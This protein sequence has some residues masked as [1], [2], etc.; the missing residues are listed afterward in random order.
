MKK[1]FSLAKA[2]PDENNDSS[3]ADRSINTGLPTLEERALYLARAVLGK[4][5]FTGAELDQARQLIIEA[6]AEEILDQTKPG[7]TRTTVRQPAPQPA[8]SWEAIEQVLAEARA[9]LDDKPQARYSA[10]YSLY[11]GPSLGTAERLPLARE[12]RSISADVLASIRSSVERPHHHS[13]G[14]W[15]A[16]IAATGVLAVTAIVWLG[17]AFDWLNLGPTKA[18]RTAEVQT[19]AVRPAASTVI[20]S[21]GNPVATQQVG[22]SPDRRAQDTNSSATQDTDKPFLADQ[23]LQGRALIASGQ[24]SAGRTILESATEAGSADAALALAT[25]HDPLFDRGLPAF[26]DTTSYAAQNVLSFTERG[27]V[28]PLE[29]DIP[30]ALQWYGK[31]KE[32]GSKE[33]A[34]RL[35]ILTEFVARTNRA[36]PGTGRQ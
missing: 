6:M 33:A 20:S 5:D 13:I 34:E 26:S 10:A 1:S 27:T 7:H 35:R 19:K 24:I 18:S 28:W 2:L 16:A 29:L 11:E 32:L 36:L 9:G 23:V 25:I 21:R 17:S 4:D 31:A 3:E 22:V 8:E 15:M 14:R 30:R 12:P